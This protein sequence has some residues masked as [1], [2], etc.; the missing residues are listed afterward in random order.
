M[1]MNPLASRLLQDG[2]DM[3]RRGAVADAAARY[4]QI[5]KFE[6]KNVDALCLLGLACGELK[7]FAEAVDLLR[8]ALKLAPK[9]APAHNL[10]GS[11]LKEI[12]RN[13]EALASFNRAISQQPDLMDAYVNRAD[14][15]MALNRWA[16]TVETYDRA[17]AVRPSFF[18]GWC[19]RG[20]ALE[21]MGRLEE[22]I[23]SYDRALALRADLTAAH[24]NRGNALAALGR[25]QAAVDG[26]DRALATSPG[27][28]ELHLNRGNSLT[29]L[30]R[31]EQALTSYD[32]ALAIRP[33]MAEAQFGRGIVF[34]DQ[35]R[36][37]DAVRCFNRAI[38]L[39]RNDAVRGLFHSHRAEAL[40]LLGRFQEAFADVSRCLEVAPNDDEALYA[41]SLIELLH[42]R[43]REAWSRYERR[44]ALKIGIPEGFS[45]PPWP[46]WR[47]EPLQDELLVLRGEQGLGDHLLFSC[48]G[49]HLAK[50]GYRIALWTKPS[51]EPLLRTVPGVERIVCDIAALEGSRD[52]RWTSM[53]SVP[54]ILG[55]TPETVPRNGSFLA[56]EPDRVAAWRERLGGQGFKIG[57]AW[58]NAGASHLDKLR[59]APLREFAALSEIPGVRL[60]SLQKGRG[61]EEIQAVGFGEQ[62]ETLGDD[63][64]AGGGAFLDTAA[65][66][67]NL[68]LIVTPCN[69]IAH[70][71]GALGRPTFVALMHVP[72]WR[73]LLDRDD[74]PWYPATRLFRQS[75]AGDWAGVFARI[76]DAVR[77]RTAQ[78][79]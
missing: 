7:R 32:R 20:V 53:M 41:V 76:A 71:A 16:E 74:S 8:K 34:R 26:F 15:L 48:F 9:H 58:Q 18:Q 51:L 17:L 24:A 55:V 46:P 77:A 40:N 12:G 65:V 25:H 42:G 29:R 60:I 61:V 28:A 79:N 35:T 33:D 4:T 59:S 36:F 30:G 3:H 78:A 56:A 52:L 64:D 11:A 10:L 1:V 44:I 72:E 66:M 57:I 31:H 70:V 27:F 37:E 6:P 68:D 43:W 39:N 73:W 62:I 69:A 45:P 47:G 14:L 67:M 13:E 5:L 54:G 22:A 21:R 19:N 38:E 49:A 2:L 75:C 63:F 23:A 50:L